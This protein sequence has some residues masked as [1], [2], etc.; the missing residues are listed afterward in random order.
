MFTMV[1]TRV[2]IETIS[3]LK[4][5]KSFTVMYSIGNT[6]FLQG[7]DLTAYRLDLPYPTALYH[8]I[9]LNTI[10]HLLNSERLLDKAE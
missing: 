3:K 9:L 1:I 7:Q 10:I 4:V 8:I 6:P 5:N 2:M